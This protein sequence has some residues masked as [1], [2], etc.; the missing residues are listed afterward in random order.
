MQMDLKYSCDLRLNYVQYKNVRIWK[1]KHEETGRNSF[2]F[3]SEKNTL[4][5]EEED[6]GMRGGGSRGEGV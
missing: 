6:L 2:F 3:T 4:E 5:E 1:S